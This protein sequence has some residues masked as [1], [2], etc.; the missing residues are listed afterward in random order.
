MGK[1]TGIK[2]PKCGKKGLIHPPHAH[3]LGWK[4]Y[5]LVNCRFCKSSWVTKDFDNYIKREKCIEEL[6]EKINE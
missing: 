1:F 2:C 5:G 6:K 4:E 3:A